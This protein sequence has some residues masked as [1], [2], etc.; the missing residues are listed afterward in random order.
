MYET[1]EHVDFEVLVVE[2]RSTI[3]PKEHK[4]DVFDCHKTR[5]MLQRDSQ[6]SLICLKK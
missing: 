6:S 4:S 2:P 3:H 1:L 5:Q